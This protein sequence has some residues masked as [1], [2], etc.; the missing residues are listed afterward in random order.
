[1]D[2]IG[3]S[4][5]QRSKPVTVSKTAS[6]DQHR[7]AIAVKT[8]LLLDGDLVRLSHRLHAGK[9]RDEQE[10]TGS[11]QVKIRYKR[12]DDAE[13]KGRTDGQIGVAGPS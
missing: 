12:I 13:I 4:Y 9:C 10:Q 6:E 3:E 2:A 7:I 5:R 8:I 11:R 1:M